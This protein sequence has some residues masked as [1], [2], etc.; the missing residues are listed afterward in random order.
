LGEAQMLVIKQ[1][2]VRV[3]AEGDVR[4]GSG[5]GGGGGLQMHSSATLR[6]VHS[7]YALS[8]QSRAVS[9]EVV[10]CSVQLRCLPPPTTT[11]P[12]T[13]DDGVVQQLKSHCLLQRCPPVT[14]RSPPPGGQLTME[15]K[16]R[17]PP[18]HS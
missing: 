2:Q 6:L 4:Q 17:G 10:F 16:Q 12:V 7:R 9:N 13:D 8:H 14:V 5:V 11:L 15:L 18:A 1:G 3:W